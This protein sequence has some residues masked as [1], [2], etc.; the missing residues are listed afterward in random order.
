MYVDTNSRHWR[1]LWYLGRKRIQTS[2][3]ELSDSRSEMLTRDF[4]QLLMWL[5]SLGLTLPNSIVMSTADEN[6]EHYT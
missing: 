1:H 5:Y 6:E 2:Q 3:Q 4:C